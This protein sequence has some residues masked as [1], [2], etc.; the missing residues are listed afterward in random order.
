MSE[1]H[2]IIIDDSLQARKLLRLMLNEIAPD[3]K[4]VA[5]AEDAD[6][7][8]TLINI[9]KP[10]VIFL[11]IEMP[12]RSGV[13]LAEDLFKGKFPLQIVFTTAYNEYAVE[14]FRL[15]AV[16]YLLKPIH[17]NHLS[18]AVE[19]VRKNLNQ[20]DDW[21]RLEGFLTNM[22][23]EQA[24]VIAV[25]VFNGYQN[26]DLERLSYIEA[27]GSYTHI[28]IDG[29]KELTISKNLKYFEAILE[30]NQN[31]LRVHRSYL[32]NMNHVIRVER[33]G[34]GTLVMSNGS[35]IDIARDRRDYIL[36]RVK[37]D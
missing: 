27:D 16:D 21:S 3:I 29:V 19:K 11:D 5:E 25:P 10:H 34:R 33:R 15:S 31:F 30:S 4:V 12:G 8:K 6:S 7:G 9:H 32:I 36:S 24:K 18:E 22:H 1:L 2:A 20:Q 37:P 35:E 28:Y 17:E 14:A 26:I 13:Q 23:S